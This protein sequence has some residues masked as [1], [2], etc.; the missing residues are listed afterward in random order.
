M[1]DSASALCERYPQREITSAIWNYALANDWV[2]Q[3]SNEK[4]WVFGRTDTLRQIIVPRS[5]IEDLPRALYEV[6]IRLMEVHRLSIDEAIGTIEAAIKDYPFDAK[7]HAVLPRITKAGLCAYM[8]SVG[9]YVRV[10]SRRT[11]TY[12]KRNGWSPLTFQNEWDWV[13][14][15]TNFLRAFIVIHREPISKVLQEL[16][17]A[18]EGL[19]SP[20]G[21]SS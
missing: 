2:V 14:A 11:T 6:L 17:E 21:E 5:E 9:W 13:P 8:N 10:T 1:A 18:Q 15:A 3:H 16:L 7:I 4:R 12:D 20:K 19:E